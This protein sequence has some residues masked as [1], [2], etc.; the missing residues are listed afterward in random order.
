MPCDECP[1]DDA[2]RQ[3]YNFPPGA[4][5]IVYRADVPDYGAGPSKSE[6]EAADAES[7]QADN[8]D[9]AKQE[10]LS[11]QSKDVHYKLQAMKWGLVP[12][13]TKRS[14]D[15]GSV[16]RTINCRDDSL[17]ENRGM[18]TGMKKRKRCIVLCQGFYEWLK[19]PNSKDKIPHFVKR[20]DGQL[21]CFA[22]LW[23]CVKY[24]GKLSTMCSASL[25]FQRCIA[26]ENSICF[27]SQVQI[28]NINQAR[29]R[30]TT[31]IQSSRQTLT[32]SSNFY[33]TG[34]QLSSTTAQRKSARG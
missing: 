31:H 27:S 6:L 32:N 4:F 18:W 29:T 3:T 10:P 19:K 14:P 1:D 30:S 20:K 13:W 12:S 25:L 21:M 22:G 23:D 2:C 5:G 9:E 8:L 15:Y 16:M 28:T 17:I 26:P 7:A 24:D 34:C 33:M 11:Q